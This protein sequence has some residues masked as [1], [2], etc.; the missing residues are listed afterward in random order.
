[1]LE[2][3]YL[4]FAKFSYVPEGIVS[5]M[6]PTPGQLCPRCSAL[7]FPSYFAAQTSQQVENLIY[8]EKHAF[9]IYDEIL[10][11]ALTCEFCQIVV[12]ALANGAKGMEQMDPRFTVNRQSI[13]VYL[14][15]SLAG[16]YHDCLMVPDD[17][18]AEPSKPLY[19]G[20][21]VVYSD[22]KYREAAR[23]KQ[24]DRGFIRLL[25]NDT[26]LLGEEPMYHGRI[27]TQMNQIYS[28]AIATLIAAE[29][30]HSNLPLTRRNCHVVSLYP[31]CTVPG[32]SKGDVV[33]RS[34]G[35]LESSFA[36]G[37]PIPLS[38][39]GSKQMVKNIQGLRLMAALPTGSDTVLHS[40]WN[41][42]A[43]T[44]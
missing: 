38:M 42:R 39:G 37:P 23:A 41:T 30:S 14:N 40:K 13:K 9:G 15:R 11:K 19:V 20:C 17:T 43:W 1:M 28:R 10:C 6:A 29:G 3:Q 12:E 44:M 18:D 16:I 35:T 26:H 4:G 2:G 25:A 32:P 22:L 8:D 31:Q 36:A 34:L 24:R 21:M 33:R 5:H 27:I 7:D